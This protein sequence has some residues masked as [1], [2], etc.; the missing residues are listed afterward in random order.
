MSG[1]SE[2]KRLAVIGHP[3]GHSRSPAMQN[4]AL[5][6]LGLDDE[7]IYEDP[8]DVVPENF[9]KFV[10]AMPERGFVGVNATIPHKQAA[11]ILADQASHVA[12]AIGAANTL[13]FEGGKIW[14]ENTDAGGLIDALPGRVQAR[15]ALV[16]GAG[17]A[18]RAV[19]WALAKESA[20]V[21]VVDVWNRTGQRAAEVAME[22]GAAPVEHPKQAS[23]GVI[24]NTTSVGLRGEDPFCELPPLAEDE[25]DS[26][27]VVVDLVY[28]DRPTKLIEVAKSAGAHTIDGI[29]ILVRQGARSFELWTGRKPPLDVMDK[30]ARQGLSR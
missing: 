29:D 15:R 14:V 1:G 18:A 3:V 17:G 11:L 21:D 22:L 9:E 27:Q 4:A 16:L 5:R 6:A 12:H 28:G 25:F 13:G 7:W 2:K 10:R 20:V 23:Y 8:I 30:A 24:V 26:E 19:I